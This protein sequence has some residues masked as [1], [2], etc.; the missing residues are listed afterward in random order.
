[1]IDSIKIFEQ[2]NMA[3]INIF[4]ESTMW[5]KENNIESHDLYVL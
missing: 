1:M 4:I 2:F 5:L 3:A